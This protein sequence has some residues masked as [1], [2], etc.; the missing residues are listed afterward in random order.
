MDFITIMTTVIGV[1]MAASIL[2]FC[3]VAIS[4]YL[5]N[6]EKNNDIR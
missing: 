3:S 1:G 2:L 6:K 4:V 5:D